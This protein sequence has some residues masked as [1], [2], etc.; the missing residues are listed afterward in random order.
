MALQFV[1]HQ[2]EE[3]CLAAVKEN[4]YALRLVK[5]EI[6]TEEFLLRCLENNI[7]CIKYIEV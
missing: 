6:K 3:I 5:P 7:A 1:K 2:T 4:S